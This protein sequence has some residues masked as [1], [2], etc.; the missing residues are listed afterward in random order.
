MASISRQQLLILAVLL[1]FVVS[2]IGC[3]ILV[4]FGRVAPF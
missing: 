2:V 1:Y 3:L 4:A